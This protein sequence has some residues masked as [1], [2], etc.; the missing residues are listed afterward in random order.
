MI[1]LLLLY[2]QHLCSG[3][4]SSECKDKHKKEKANRNI[5]YKEIAKPN[6]SRSGR[7]NKMPFYPLIFLVTIMVPLIFC[8]GVPLISDS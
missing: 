4:F 8:F 2:G 1:L 5:L 7:N 6:D 3:D